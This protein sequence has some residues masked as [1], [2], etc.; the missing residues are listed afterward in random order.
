MS[1]K[2]ALSQCYFYKGESDCP[3]ALLNADNRSC[4]FWAAEE[5]FVQSYG[6]PFES[7]LIE[8]Y[9][10][11]GLAGLDYDLPLGLLASLF[12]LYCKS[13][14]ASIDVCAAE[15]SEIVYPDYIQLTSK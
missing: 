13:A 15:F 12:A 4:A 1:K 6:T 11:A 2:D 9:L 3:A 7:K 10:D 14:D 5:L 8:N